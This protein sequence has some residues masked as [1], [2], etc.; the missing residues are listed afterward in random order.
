[1][2]VSVCHFIYL[3][4]FFWG[5]NICFYIFYDRWVHMHEATVKN[6]FVFV[7]LQNT[8]I[9]YILYNDQK[10]H[11]DSSGDRWVHNSESRGGHTKGELSDCPKTAESFE[12]CFP[13]SW[14][15]MKKMRWVGGTTPHQNEPVE[16]FRACPKRRRIWGRPE[17]CQIDYISWLACEH[18]G[19]P[20]G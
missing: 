12:L 16:V 4:V 7:F 2:D 19:S 20:P 9:A 11:E 3:F 1:M 18:V 13:K 10:P 6:L 5:A 15:S 8:D 14:N 17:T